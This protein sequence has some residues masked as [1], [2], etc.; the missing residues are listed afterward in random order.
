MD[1]SAIM[2]L[3]KQGL[4]AREIAKR[5]GHKHQSSVFKVMRRI[6][7]EKQSLC[8]VNKTESSLVFKTDETRFR[9]ASEHF[10]KYFFASKGIPFFEGES[11]SP[12]DLLIHMDGAYKKVQVKSSVYRS[13]S[14][15]FSFGLSR[16][17]SNTTS[18]RKV[19]YSSDE[20]DFFFL[21]DV[22]L[23]AWIIPH[24][25]I[26]KQHSVVPELRFPGY[27]VVVAK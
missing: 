1:E 4:G 11:G 20:C 13:R 26:G 15:H 2:E 8:P 18:T 22:K 14:G 25:I 17:R 3:S 27:K 12:F 5:L 16:V 7:C 10:A 9:Y 24:A 23:N 21:V 19:L 6:G